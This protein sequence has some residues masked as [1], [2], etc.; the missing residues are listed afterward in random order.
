M[1]QIKR[2]L[3]LLSILLSMVCIGLAQ[4]VMPSR[5]NPTPPPFGSS[6]VPSFPKG[7]DHLELRREYGQLETERDLLQKQF[8]QQSAEIAKTK[9]R[10]RTSSTGFGKWLA[11]RDLQQQIENM[12]QTLNRLDQ[13]EGRQ[14]EI[15]NISR[16]IVTQGP[17]APRQNSPSLLPP[18]G[19]DIPG[20]PPYRGTSVK[21]MQQRLEELKQ[22]RDNS[23]QRTNQYN[24]EIQEL[25]KQLRYPQPKTNTPHGNPM[26]GPNR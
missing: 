13:I 22:Q 17:I 7:S 18:P 4:P 10:I 1:N 12:D 14:K 2:V 11:R 6:D 26:P 5:P 20:I 15:R 9:Q 24:Q 16:E 21:Q 19:G 8:A 25:E 23:I 3:V